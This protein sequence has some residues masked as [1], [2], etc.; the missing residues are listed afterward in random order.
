MRILI[1]CE[2]SGVIRDEF[3]KRGH[4][5]V[6]CDYLETENPGPHYQGNVFDIIDE[7][8]DLMIAHPPCTYLTV[9]GNIWLYHPDDKKKP[10]KLRRRHPR[11]KSRI[12]K[13]DKAI[14]FFKDLFFAPIKKVVIE[15]P[16]GIM[17]TV[18]REPIQYIQPYQFGEPYTKKTGLWIR[19]LPKLQPT[20]IV[21]PKFYVCANG[22]RFSPLYIDALSL[23]PEEREKERSRTFKGIAEAMAIQWGRK[24]ATLI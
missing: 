10:V 4:K 21:E 7:G 9:S 16:V 17:S 15:N 8:W 19:G 23:S 11:F 13:R 2:F 6:S 5:A 20:K 12:K 1:A 22:K 24:Q 18:F 3:I 14:K